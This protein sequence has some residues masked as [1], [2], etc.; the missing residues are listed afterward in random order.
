MKLHELEIGDTRAGQPRHGD[1]VAGRDLAGWSSRDRPARRR[2]S[3]AASARA[4]DLAQPPPA[5]GSGRRR[6]PPSLEQSATAPARARRP[7]PADAPVARCPQHAADLAAR[8]V[9][10]VQ[11][12]PD[13]VR[14]FARRAPAGRRHRDRR[15]RPRRELGDIARAALDQHAHGRRVAQAVAG[16]K[17]S[18]KCSSGESSDRP[19][20][21]CRPGRSRCCLRPDAALVSTQHVARGGELDRRTQARRCRCRPR[22][23]GACSLTLGCRPAKPR[24]ASRFTAH[25]GGPAEQPIGY[26]TLP[27]GSR[28]RMRAPTG[29]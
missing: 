27:R 28:A 15:P 2:R 9:A 21:R 6:R 10:R 1:A 13:A 14:R 11:H 8:G 29:P 26:P 4:R 24:S 16:G 17:V 3:R 7:A 20:R 18:W 23:S 12:A 5:A 19:R 22:G 25:T